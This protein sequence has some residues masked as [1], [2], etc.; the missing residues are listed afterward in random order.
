M[1]KE[2]LDLEVEEDTLVDIPMC[3]LEIRE[4]LNSL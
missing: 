4:L 3:S 2:M 1:K